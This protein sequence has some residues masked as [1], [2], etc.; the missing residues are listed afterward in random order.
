MNQHNQTKQIVYETFFVYQPDATFING[1]KDIIKQYVTDG[2]YYSQVQDKML[3]AKI[4]LII[5]YVTGAYIESIVFWIKENYETSQEDMASSLID[6]SLYGP[7][8]DKLT[9]EN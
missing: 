2:I 7:Y 9:S 5:A 4:D 8:F 3:R 1:V 6:I